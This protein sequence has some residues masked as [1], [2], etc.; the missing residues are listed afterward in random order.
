MRGLF[1]TISRSLLL[2]IVFNALTLLAPSARAASLPPSQRITIN[3]GETPWLYLFGDPTGAQAPNFPDSTWTIVGIPYS[4][5]QLDTFINAQS[6]GGD[7]DLNGPISWYRNHFTLNPSNAGSKV[8]VEFEGAHTGVQVFINGTLLPGISAVPA[9]AQATHVV[10]FIPFIV[11]LTPYVKFDGSDNVLAVRAAKNAAFFEAPGFSQ[12]FRFG[13]SDSGL[14]RPVDMFITNPVHIPANVYSNLATWGTYVTTLSADANSAQ[15]DVQTNVLNESSTPQ[16]VTLTAQIVDAGGNIVASTVANQTIAPNA[17]PGLHPTLFDTPMTVNNPTLWY[18]NNSLYGKPYMYK[19]FH[20][21]SVNGVVVDAVQSPLG[22]RT[23]TWDA[24]FPYINGKMQY[25]W[26]ASGR[27]D[28]PALGTAVPE[29]QKWRDLRDLAAAGGNLWRPGH[30][31]ESEEFVNAADA[32]GIMIVQPS[33]EGEGAFNQ[34]CSNPPCDIQTLKSELHRDMI[35]RDRNHPSILAWEADNGDIDT[36]FAQSLKALSVQWDPNLPR[37]QADR[38]P[39]P[40]NGDILGCTLEGCEVLTKQ[41]YPD[42]PAWG[43]EY[44]GTGTARQA[45]D[46]ELAFAAPF[47]DNWRKSRLANAFG[48]AQWYFADSPGEDSNYVEGVPETSVRSLG[49]SMTDMNRFPKL[50][51][52][53]YQA[54]WTPFSIQPVVH[55]AHHWNRGGMVQEN[56][57][58]NCPSVNLLIN[59]VSQGIQTPN[60]WNV[61][62]ATNLTQD[63]TVMPFQAHWNVTWQSGTVTAQ[64]LDQYG[65]VLATDSRT[66]AGA[67]DHIELDLVPELVKPDGTSFTISANGSD[68]AFVVAKVVDANGVVVPTASN[69]ITFS[70]SG[71]ATYVGGSEQYVVA[72]EPLGYHAPGDPELSA[73]GGMTK[74]ALRSQFQLGTVTVTAT[75]PGLGNGM[76]SYQIGPIQNTNPVPAAPAI[77]VAPLAQA[78]TAGQPA[79][80]SVTATG[81]APLSFQWLLNGAPIANANGATYQTGGTTLAENGDAYSVTVSNSL[82]NATSSAAVLTVVAPAAVTIVAAPASQ[83]VTIGQTAM[84]S[85]V[86]NGSPTLSYQWSVNN[87]PITG[88]TGTSYTTPVLGA[89]DNGSQFTVAVSNPVNAVTTAPATLTVGAAVAPAITANPQNL[90]VPQNQPAMFTVTASG[91]APLA[92]QWFFNGLPISAA[93]GTSLII[94]AVQSGNAGSYTVT[95]TNIAGTVTSTPATLTI[96][97]P[98]ANLALFGKATASS[99]ENQ[100]SMPASAAFDGNL[101]TRWGSAIGVDP[102]WIEVDLGATMGFNNVVIYWQQAYASVYKIQ[103]SNDGTKWKT[104]F[105]QSNGQGGIETLSFK[106][107]QGRYVRMYGEKRATQYGYSLFEM[108]VFDADQCGGRTERYS[109]LSPDKLRDN[110]T[111][112]SWARAEY[113]Y[114]NGAA[115]F[116]EPLAEAYCKTMGMRLPTLA[117]AMSITGNNDAQCG[118]PLSWLT[119]TT[120]KYDNEKGYDYLVNSAGQTTFG[121]ADNYPGG[122]LCVAGKP[123]DIAPPTITVQPLPQ[124]VTVGAIA[125]FSVMADGTTPIAYQWYRNGAPMLGATNATYQTQPTALTDNGTEIS[126]AVTGPTGLL[127]QSATATLTVQAAPPFFSTQP[128]PQTIALGQ[129]ATFSVALAGTGPFSTQWYRNGAAISGATSTAYT[130]PPAQAGDNGSFYDVIA[131][132][133][134]GL[135]AQSTIVE[136]AVSGT[137]SGGTDLLAIASGTTEPV[138]NFVADEDFSGGGT[139]ASPNATISVAGVPDAAPEAVYQ[140][141]RN[142]AFSYTIGG[143]T[144]NEATTLRLH[145]AELFWPQ[146]GQ[147]IFGVT[148]NKAQALA[149]FDIVAAAG[150]PLQ[151]L[152]ENFTATA[153]SQGQIAIGFVMG[154]QDQPKLSGIELVQP[155]TGS[156]PVI[157][158]Q[159]A[160]QNVMVGQ[161]ATFSVAASGTGPFTYRWNCNNVPI[162]GANAASYTTPATQPGNAGALYQAVVTSPSGEAVNSTVA[163]LGVDGPGL[164]LVAINAGAGYSTGVFAADTDYT[165][166]GS[167]LS[168]NA[169]IQTSGIPNAAPEQIYRASRQ[170]TSSYVIPNLPQGVTYAIRL[171]FAE[172]YFTQPGQRVFNVAIND[173][174]LPSPIDIVQDAGGPNIALVVNASASADA[175]GNITI[176]FTNG[177]ANQPT[178]SGIEIVAPS[179]MNALA[180]HGKRHASART[181]IVPVAASFDTDPVIVTPPANTTVTIGTTAQFS[182]TATGKGRLR[183]QWAEN[184]TEIAGA[185]SATYTTLGTTAADSAASFTVTVTDATGNT[186]TASATLTVDTTPPYTV[187][188]GTIVTA[189]NNNTRGAWSDSQ[190]YVVIL[191]NDVNT[192]ALSWVQ[193]NGTVTPCAVADNT[194]PGHL[195][196][197]NGQSYPNYAFTLA[198]S[199]TLM[200][201]P[202]SSARA[203]ISLGSPLFMEIVQ[204]GNGNVGYAGPNP[205]NNTDPNI[206]INYDWYEFN[207]NGAIFINTTQ[208]DEFGLPMLLDLWGQNETFHMQTGINEPVAMIDKEFVKE[209]PKPFH[210]NP[211]SPLRILAPG[212]ASMAPGGPDANYFDKYVSDIW[213]LYKKTPLVV[214]LYGGQREFSGTTTPNSFVFTE[215][216]QNN[217]HYV[218]GT[219]TIAGPQSTQDIV[220]CNNTLANGN[221]VELAIEAQFCAA[222]N[223]HVMQSYAEWAQV[224]DYYLGTPENAYAQFW[225]KHSVSGLA[226]G[227]AYD[228]VNSQSSTIVS[229]APEYMAWGIGW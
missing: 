189:L 201:P 64:C 178:V 207:Y 80:F 62:S 172:L 164:D 174:P 94:P 31:T 171:H 154:Q 163:T 123:A 38:T 159:P 134:T 76:V 185:T 65:N 73:E 181:G 102:S 36:P 6:G 55:L 157:T 182:V 22:I 183:Y 191:G 25:L 117:E 214:Y 28:Y 216:N 131:T 34:H 148:I 60:P 14:F 128:S 75:S 95:V 126:V 143:L 120:T 118:F 52:Y 105:T 35:I 74:I 24:N 63:T 44:W 210:T 228:D 222:Y 212:H 111:H 8:L 19:V 50:L 51:Y 193:A 107:V 166:G 20:I 18:P 162:Q 110:L 67:P 79:Q 100:V 152:A 2:A 37:V 175:N 33:G 97:P 176:A 195:V 48:I 47:L 133:P 113:T 206:N 104:A 121:V 72:N 224:S 160:S 170:G 85:V 127:V 227:F 150:A 223:R 1:Q 179:G 190:I 188:P 213:K 39:N 45:W 192:G 135:A 217:G 10:G 173:V 168:Q 77:I 27:Y 208:V 197:P 40:A 109:V 23:I 7:G 32:Y 167:N 136:L 158:A 141:E 203:F 78:V 115:Q 91:S 155:G 112:L 211:I 30:S 124:T 186:A 87:T 99:Y 86:A 106:T 92:Y 11:D 42:S 96:A 3:M 119:W 221:S 180:L 137:G 56:A 13:Q 220:Y 26:G 57:F 199:K 70:V 101:T 43:S 177:A 82:G 81:A 83:S 98:G 21:V 140:S 41:E 9:D 90:S 219:Y 125:T 209:T 226:Y 194:A 5:D 145:F 169:T 156:A 225:H 49:A 114:T 61:D 88:A 122:A 54:A 132:G 161:T 129:T 71:P 66:T 198:Q 200:L 205:L 69:A 58:S 184:G 142:G 144:P 151:A 202:L 215:I 138:G 59:G 196:G 116:T 218:G 93:N 53:V 12:G 153:N 204:G 89:A 139:S 187:V 16:Q 108:Q 68:A 130:T 84:F 146:P 15:I 165:G 229:S 4:A 149:D 103:Y 147:R 29:E 17:G 46:F